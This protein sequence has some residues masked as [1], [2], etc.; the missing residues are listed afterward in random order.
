M[1]GHM[2]RQHLKI[3]DVDKLDVF[4][5]LCFQEALAPGPDVLLRTSGIVRG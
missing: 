2:G 3:Y 5:V 1:W 4:Y